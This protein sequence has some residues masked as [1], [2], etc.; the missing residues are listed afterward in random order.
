LK[1]RGTI[2]LALAIVVVVG[3]GCSLIG[4]REKPVSSYALAPDGKRIAFSSNDGD[5]Y[6]LELETNKVKQLTSTPA[7]EKRPSFSPDGKFILYVSE[8]S[9]DQFS[10]RV[11]RMQIDNGK[12]QQLTSDR[13]ISDNNPR[14]SLD[15]SR[16]MFARA[17]R[18]NG[19]PYVR[20]LWNDY[21][22]YVMSADGSNMKRITNGLYQ[23]ELDG[24]FSPDGS[25][26]IFSGWN[27]SDGRGSSLFGGI[28]KIKADGSEN[29]PASIASPPPK[30]ENDENPYGVEYGSPDLSADGNLIV[31]P[32]RKRVRL[33][34]LSTK[35]FTDLDAKM[36]EGYGYV[37]DPVF[38]PDGKRI[39]LMKVIPNEN[40]PSTRSLV[41][42]D[43]DGKNLKEI[44]DEEIFANP[45]KWKPKD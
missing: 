42:M 37:A 18:N 39:F 29:K 12:I 11:F 17:S 22:L 33:M 26:L 35:E 24:R 30:N 36:P 40:G 45:L 16:I 9:G 4:H 20:D 41:S 1:I 32:V 31:F 8:P 38:T 15:G 7:Y 14:Y 28:L 13:S 6:L 2:L 43:L 23:R 10:S 34:D 5:L 3:A 27:F 19:D 44:A 25:F 21:D